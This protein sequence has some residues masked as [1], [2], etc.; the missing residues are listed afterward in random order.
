MTSRATTSQRRRVAGGQVAPQIGQGQT[1]VDDVLDDEHVAAGQ[2]ELQVL[3]DAHHPAGVGGAAVGRDGHEVDLDREIDGAGQVGQEKAGPFEHPDQQRGPAGVVGRDL[4]AEVANPAL[5]VCLGDH[6]VDRR[7][8]RRRGRID[9]TRQGGQLGI[10]RRPGL[11]HGCGDPTG[12]TTPAARPAC[13]FDAASAG[14]LAR[15]DGPAGNRERPGPPRP[16]TGGWQLG[17][18]R[19][20]Q[21]RSH[22]RTARGPGDGAR[23]GQPAGVGG[24]DVRRQRLSSRPA[25]SPSSAAWR[26]STGT[27]SRPATSDSRGRTSA[28]HPVAA[29]PEVPVARIVDGHETLGGAQG[30]RLPAPQAEHGRSAAGRPGRVRRGRRRRLPAARPA[31]V[32][33]DLMPDRPSR[34]APRSMASSTV[35]AWSSMVWPVSTP[36]GRTS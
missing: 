12:P 32:R 4:G 3:E 19:W 16:P 20:P 9:S 18:A 2:V 6:D 15:P 36:G 26:A 5:E 13:A 29:E 33:L 14:Q 17:V 24:I 1:R 10:G 21:R 23:A 7:R 8:G 27:R 30:G 28:A 31:P 22:R 34:A 35:S 25:S 11:G